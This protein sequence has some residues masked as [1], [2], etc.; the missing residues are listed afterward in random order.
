MNCFLEKTTG[1]SEIEQISPCSSLQEWLLVVV[2][3]EEMI[4]IHHK[5]GKQL[6]SVSYENVYFFFMMGVAALN[7]HFLNLFVQQL[8]SFHYA[9]VT[10]TV[11]RYVI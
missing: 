5:V 6:G 10:V 11:C 3:Q 1:P 8:C 4:A 7:W 2:S 9:F